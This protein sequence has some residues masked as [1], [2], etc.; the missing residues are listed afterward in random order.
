LFLN[1]YK[2]GVAL[3]DAEL[4]TLLTDLESDRAERKASGADRS[5]IRRA[6]CAFANDLP[7][8]A[9]PGVIFVGAN[10]D[11]TCAG[12]VISD[13][14]LLTLSQMRTDG[15]ILPPPSLVVEKRRLDGCELAVVI[16]QPSANPPVRYKGR[17][18]VRVGPAVQQATAEEERQ[19]AE[20]RRSRDLPFDSR[21][22][23]G[24]QL[25]ELDLEFIRTQYFPLGVAPEVLEQNQRALDQQLA[26]LRFLREGA[27]TY[28]AITLFGKDPL[29]WLPGA[30]VQ[31]LRIEGQAL[32]DPVRDDKRLSGPLHE[33]LRQLEELLQVNVQTA[34]EPSST[35]REFPRPDYPTAA[36]RQFTRNALMHRNY[37]ESNAPTRVYWFSDRIEISNPGGL[38]GQVTRDNFGRGATD[39]RNP[40]IA[41]AMRNLGYVQRFGMGI[42]LAREA[43]RRNGNPECEFRFEPSSVLVVVR[44]AR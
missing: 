39:Y 11:G 19:L 23:E 27:P 31:F 3:A 18:W 10:N 37:E 25:D 38:F 44:P 9:E 40:L 17:V 35:A 42:P 14:L 6:I 22:A 12:L 32:T 41:E 5:S 13:Q 7:D 15:N 29:R 43:L 20:R 8:H 2:K 1:R 30:Y 26:S 24:A 33:V 16:V 34:G 28:G 36:L 21:P 4:R